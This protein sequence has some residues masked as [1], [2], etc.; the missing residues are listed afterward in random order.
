MLFVILFVCVLCADGLLFQSKSES[1]LTTGQET[2]S[3]QAGATNTGVGN[4][5]AACETLPS[6]LSSE[7]NGA[8]FGSNNKEGMCAVGKDIGDLAE[9]MKGIQETDDGEEETS[10]SC[11]MDQF[12][13][14][15]VCSGKNCNIVV[16]ARLLHYLQ[17]VSLYLPSILITTSCLPWCSM[18]IA[19]CW[20]LLHVS[21]LP[22][23]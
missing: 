14:I 7:G 19:L 5:A 21:M 8:D 18:Q 20:P 15:H 17:L 22:L 4:G 23:D 1:T 2:R 9:K 6:P 10:E 12:Q 3:Q 13:Q 11:Q 16:C